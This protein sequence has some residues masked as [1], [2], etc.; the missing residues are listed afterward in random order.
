MTDFNTQLKALGEAMAAVIEHDECPAWLARQIGEFTS[1]A[2][3]E[4]HGLDDSE[5]T[6]SEAR[7]ILPYYLTIIGARAGRQDGPQSAA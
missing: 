1:A 7:R 2:Y 5:A 4:A 6:A 3:N